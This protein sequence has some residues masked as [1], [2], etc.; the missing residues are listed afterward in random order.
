MNR[1]RPSLTRTLLATLI[2]TA[3]IASCS[4][5]ASTR[6][7]ASD[8]GPTTT[9]PPVTV[10]ES[11]PPGTK[12]RVGDQLEYAAFVGCPP[13]LQAFQGDAI[14]AGFVASTPLIFAQAAGQDLVAI[15]GWASDRG[16][17]GLLAVDD[18]I[19]GWE[20][21]KGKRVAYQ[22]G[23][24]AEAAV[25]SALDAAGIDPSEITT[26]DVPITQINA[27]LEGGSADAALS[28]E[29]LI[30]LF[31]AGHPEAHVAAVPDAITDR[32]QFLIASPSALDDPAKTAALADYLQRLV[33]AFGYIREHPEDLTRSVFVEQYGLAPERAAELVDS[34]NG[35]TRFFA[36]PGDVL[37]AQ[38]QLADLFTEAGQIPT[39]LDVA[40]QFDPRFNDL[41]AEEQ[42]S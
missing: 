34:G 4:S 5:D 18:S 6:A 13:M 7:D 15:A 12:L 31:L 24:S 35:S 25:L 39:K 42:G 3:A 9:A 38:Q 26:V 2:A 36:V 11:I 22:R 27:A 8:A 19:Q 10:P 23:T 17:G 20:D 28:T 21:L 40:A 14:D 41:V 1:R 29:P 32:G 33:R 37:E 30:S 16:L